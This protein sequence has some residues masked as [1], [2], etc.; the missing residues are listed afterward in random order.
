MIHSGQIKNNLDAPS[1]K[2]IKNFRMATRTL[3]SLGVL[4]QLFF[5]VYIIALYG[6]AALFNNFEKVNEQNGHGITEGD[7]MGNFAFGVHVFLAAVITLGGPIQFINWIRARYPV[8]HRWNGRIYYVTAFLISIAGLYMNFLRGAHGG[9]IGALGNG[10]N[11]GLIMT[12][13][14]LAWRTALQR[15]FTAHKKWAIRAFLMVSGV[16]FFRIGYGIWI[17]LTGFSGFGSSPNLDGP[18]DIF[19]FFG[20]SLVPL[21]IIEVYFWVKTQNN[22]SITRWT[23]IGLGVLSVFL[24][25]GIVMAGM[26][27]WVPAF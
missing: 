5:V 9:T 26:I 21:F 19:L 6:G 17:L 11:A 23:T 27:F 12:F 22:L 8:F 2:V 16:W 10:L 15:D 18:F 25:I 4:G 20:H 24:A 14:I 7:T 1:K 13:S 3:F